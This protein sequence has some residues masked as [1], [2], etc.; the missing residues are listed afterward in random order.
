MPSDHV[1][2]DLLLLSFIAVNLSLKLTFPLPQQFPHE[3]PPPSPCN[4]LNVYSEQ[5]LRLLFRLSRTEEQ[6]I[7]LNCALAQPQTH[8][9]NSP[10]QL[11]KSLSIKSCKRFP[12]EMF[13]KPTS[14]WVSDFHA[15]NLAKGSAF[16]SIFLSVFC[17]KNE[18]SADNQKSRE[19]KRKFLEMFLM[20]SIK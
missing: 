2:S 17:A 11:R 20:L 18:T 4:P 6:S 3:F 9:G 1:H 5:P 15:F 7:I 13:A 19:M 8:Q 12:L 16:N 14:G 10:M